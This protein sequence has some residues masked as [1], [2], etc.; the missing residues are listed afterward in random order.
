MCSYNSIITA[1]ENDIRNDVVLRNVLQD[2]QKVAGI[3]YKAFCHLNMEIAALQ[4]GI[5]KQYEL[6]SKLQSYNRAKQ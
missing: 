1:I 3:E 6:I 4:I 5:K 2:R